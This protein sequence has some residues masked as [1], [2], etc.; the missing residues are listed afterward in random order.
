MG[1]RPTRGLESV[2][3]SQ[4]FHNPASPVA[5]PPPID[6]RETNPYSCVRSRR[7]ESLERRGGQEARGG[8][9]PHQP[10]D[11]GTSQHA[12]GY[13]LPHLLPLPRYTEID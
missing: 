3:A 13:P 4:P 10:Q 12:D 5:P 8:R 11:Q 7:R 2:G 6:R 9:R 1:N